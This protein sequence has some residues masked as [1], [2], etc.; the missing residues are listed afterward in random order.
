M[1]ANEY[2]TPN[3]VVVILLFMCYRYLTPTESK[4]Q[5]TLMFLCQPHRKN[6]DYLPESKQK[7]YLLIP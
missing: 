2:S 7:G 1:L 4:N 6:R 5:V 3:S